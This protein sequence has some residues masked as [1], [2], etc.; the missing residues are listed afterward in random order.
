MN[1]SL[2]V[3]FDYNVYFWTIILPIT[4]GVITNYIVR[5]HKKKKNNEL[6]KNTIIDWSIIMKPEIETLSGELS[7]LANKIETSINIEMP[8]VEINRTLAKKILDIN[9]SD[10]L[11][12]IAFNL[13]GEKKELIE[14]GYYIFKSL[15]FINITEN[16]ILEEYDA[17][18]KEIIEL[19][20]QWKVSYKEFTV[21]CSRTKRTEQIKELITF[22]YKVLGDFFK[23]YPPE[24]KYPII[25]LEKEVLNKIQEKIDATYSSDDSDYRDYSYDILTSVIDLKLII[26]EWKA[27]KKTYSEIYSSYSRNLEVT[28]NQL[29]KCL[30]V[31]NS[32]KHK[33]FY[34]NYY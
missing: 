9:V 16:K 25:E 32:T 27:V 22:I 20:N 21:S 12:S 26:K 13:K 24:N 28:M 11:K 18:S 15:D 7:R 33:R 2:S 17:F 10:I 23:K 8:R 4:I 1:E 14:N 29:T 34:Q 5:Q 31:V 19:T 6:I 3:A 30:S